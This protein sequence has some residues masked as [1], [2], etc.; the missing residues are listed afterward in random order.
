M[1]RKNSTVLVLCLVFLAL[2]VGCD[3]ASLGQQEYGSLEVSFEGL[4]S[5]DMY[6]P[7]HRYGC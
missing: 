4:V 7:R 3:P 2:L 1:S 5:R 6:K